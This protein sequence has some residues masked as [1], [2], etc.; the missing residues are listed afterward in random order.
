MNTPTSVYD[1]GGHE[2]SRRSLHSKPRLR[3]ILRDILF[4]SN[5]KKPIIIISSPSHK[6]HVEGF[7]GYS[8]V[9]DFGTDYTRYIVLRLGI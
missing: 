5:D 6:G 4:D 3:D 2:T 7:S 1:G 8:D 9:P